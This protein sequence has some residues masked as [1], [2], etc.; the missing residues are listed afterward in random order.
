MNLEEMEG[1]YSRLK[2]RYD[3]KELTSDQF[4]TEMLHARLQDSR[5]RY[6]M[7]DPETGNWIVNAGGAWIEGTPPAE[8]SAGQ[9][10]P[11]QET[12]DW[13]EELRPTKGTEALLESESLP[14]ALP[15]P[16]PVAPKRRRG[17]RNTSRVFILI[18]L[19]I[20]LALVFCALG[21]V[22]TN[23]FGIVDLG[24]W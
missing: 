5:G 17:R 21:A 7:I 11:E 19:F 1:L 14:V 8:L 12:S 13:L 23:G 3:A 15:V 18:M 22:L 6:W 20:L 2:A 9:S 10:A 4:R 24:L 16:P